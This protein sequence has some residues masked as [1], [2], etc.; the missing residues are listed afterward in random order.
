MAKRAR[1]V[2]VALMYA[3]GL[4]PPLA[5]LVVKPCRHIVV[6]L[7]ATARA[8]RIGMAIPLP[9]IDAVKFDL[10]RHLLP[11]NLLIHGVGGLVPVVIGGQIAL[12]ESA[13]G[14]G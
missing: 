5:R 9:R 10:A 8:A 3:E 11:G 14:T 12:A 4:G 6:E 1:L 13:R 7:E 2:R